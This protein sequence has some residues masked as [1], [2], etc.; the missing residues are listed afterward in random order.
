MGG[1]HK[2]VRPERCEQLR[3]STGHQKKEKA[4]SVCRQRCV[5]VV[6]FWASLSLALF[7]TGCSRPQTPAE[8]S[9]QQQSGKGSEATKAAQEGLAADVARYRQSFSEATISEPPE[10]EERPP[11]STVA[12]KSVGKMYEE[13]AGKD[14]RGGLWEQIPL[15]NTDGTRIRYT[16]FVK[17]DLGTISIELLSDAA[18][19]HVRNFIALAR[20]G[21]YNG[22]AFDRAIRQKVE[23]EEMKETPFEMLEA[24]CPVGTGEPGYGSIGYWLKPEIAD[25]LTH[26]EGRVGACH[27]EELESAAAK[28]YIT[29]GKSPWLDGNWTIFGKVTQGLDV[30]RTILE[31]PTTAEDP[32]RP[33]SPVQIR[34]VAIEGSAKR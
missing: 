18:P 3:S 33:Q 13:I 26:E 19:N 32:S 31:R 29:L 11:D 16:A 20:A 7:L 1:F 14:G 25:K 2:S 10:G 24:G 12:G 28:F 9:D 4:M 30:A 34:E 5:Y 8:S 27:G 23:V 15:V 21:Y 6:T 22:L 17:T